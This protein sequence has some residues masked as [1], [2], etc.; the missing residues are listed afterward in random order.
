MEGRCNDPYLYSHFFSWFSC[1]TVNCIFYHGMVEKDTLIPGED[2]MTYLEIK[3]IKEYAA[4][5]LRT[6]AIRINGQERMQ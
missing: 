5:G 4:N 2:I 3:E 1:G 6:V